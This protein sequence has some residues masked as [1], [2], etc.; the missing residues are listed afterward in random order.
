MAWLL[1]IAT[2]NAEARA[3]VSALQFNKTND[4][5]QVFTYLFMCLQART[6]GLAAM[7]YICYP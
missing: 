4:M 5:Q 7:L 3:G 6:P 2:T 1:Y